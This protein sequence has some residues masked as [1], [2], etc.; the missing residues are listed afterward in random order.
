MICQTCG[1]EFFEDYRNRSR[2]TPRFCSR[3]CSRKRVA[4]DG[5]KK[6]ASDALKRALDKLE[7]EGR[8]CE[9]CGSVFHTRDMS[10]KRCFEC[11][12][13]TIKRNTKNRIKKEVKS[14]RD[15][16]T[17]TAEKI[18]RRMG[19]PCSCCGAFVDGVHWD[20]HHIVPR[21]NGGKNEMSNLTYICPNCHRIAHTDISLLPKALVSLDQQLKDCGKDWKDF[22]YG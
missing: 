6:K 8:V 2:G 20:V 16:S 17:R 18:F 5:Q 3:K 14:I 7:F 22:Y 13:T 10:R 21:K 12:P 15:V 1:K 19:L 9:S 11:L 4:T